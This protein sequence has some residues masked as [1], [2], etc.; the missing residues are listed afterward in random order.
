VAVSVDED[1]YG[2][3]GA[4]QQM[5]VQVGVV[6]GIQVMQTVQQAR[7]PV[8]GQE[9][10]YHWGY[11]AGLVLAVVGALTATRIASGSPTTAGSGTEADAT[12]EVAAAIS[13]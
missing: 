3:A 8:V 13:T 4:A 7:L 5:V 12:A 9:A 2:V 10:S 1:D 11:L 6:F